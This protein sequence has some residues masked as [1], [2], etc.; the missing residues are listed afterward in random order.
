MNTNHNF[1]ILICFF[2]WASGGAGA[3]IIKIINAKVFL[4]TL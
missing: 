2:A 4:I 3:R 1:C